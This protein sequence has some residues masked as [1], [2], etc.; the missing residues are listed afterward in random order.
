MSAESTVKHEI[1][2][3]SEQRLLFEFGRRPRTGIF[4]LE[5]LA[6]PVRRTAWFLT[7]S[8]LCFETLVT[9]QTTG[10]ELHLPC[11]IRSTVFEGWAAGQMSND[12]LQLTIVPQL[13]G[14]LMQVTFAGH[15]Y[16]FVNPKYKGKYFP[17]SAANGKWFNYG[18]DKIWPLP[19]G[20]DDG[21]HWPGP[22]ADELDDGE[23]QL[24]TISHGSTCSVRL[25]GP[26]DMRTGLQYSREIMIGANSPEISFRSIMKNAVSRTIRWSMQTVT[27][28]DTAD[29]RNPQEYNR[30]FWALAP[31]NPQSAYSNGYQVRSGL[32]DDPSFST[33]DGM[34]LLHWLYLENEV[35]LDS[36]AGWLAVDDAANQ[37]AM[38]ERFYPQ[39]RA[40]YPGKASLIFYKNG[41]AV[42]IDSSGKPVL[43]D[44][45]PDEAPY[46]ME[47][48][49]NSPMA[50]LKP[51]ETY[52]MQTNWFPTRIAGRI[53]NVA[54]AGVIAGR[55]AASATS[56]GV[57][58]S[59][60]IGVFF[61][62]KLVAHFED[63]NGAEIK[64]VDLISVTPQAAVQ[65]RQEIKMQGTPKRVAI[66]LVDDQDKDR[67]SVGEAAIQSGAR[68]F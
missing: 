51:G 28:Y 25:D 48:E 44:A 38:V 52:E 2:F 6:K 53:T 46:Y 36:T 10:A 41:A 31:L 43:R 5:S 1:R 4:T 15:A 35:W 26:A 3:S 21:Q 66:H 11:E 19:E 56:D 57:M 54:D 18:G 47:A 14:R 65:L 42:N 29:R 8:L 50:E 23:Y 64:S 55:I 58:I 40:E 22:I 45:T 61:P 59:A 32:A 68:N 12:W 13:G 24:K 17:P 49:V 7:V 62:G 16:L 39:E 20:K 30:D 67:G 33:E 34:F 9:A 27:Q 63:G 37:Y 60:S